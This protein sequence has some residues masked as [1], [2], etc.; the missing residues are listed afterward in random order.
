MPF[1]GALLGRTG[2]VAGRKKALIQVQT[3]LWLP[4]CRVLKRDWVLASWQCVCVSVRVW[5]SWLRN[6]RSL[7]DKE[8]TL[9]SSPPSGLLIVDIPGCGKTGSPPLDVIC[10]VAI[11]AAHV[12][13]E[14]LEFK[15]VLFNYMGEGE[16]TFQIV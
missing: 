11:L 16:G 2:G 4:I 9:I 3:S 6:R 1:S 15:L 12:K 7:G 10:L 14:G 5:L 13:E 8:I